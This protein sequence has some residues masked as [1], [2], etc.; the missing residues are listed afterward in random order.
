ML[1][2]IDLAEEAKN[3]IIF[4]N[5][6]RSIMDIMLPQYAEIAYLRSHYQSAEHASRMTAM[7]SATDNAKI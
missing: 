4:S 3:W 5:R 6:T 2:I 1:P 7:R